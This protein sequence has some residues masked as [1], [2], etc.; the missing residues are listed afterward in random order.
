MTG[1]KSLLVNYSDGTNGVVTFGDGNKGVIHGKGDL[2]IAGLPPVQNVLFV[3]G[4]KANLLSISQLCD[5]H[6]T[7]SFNREKCLATSLDG[8]STLV[9]TRSADNCYMLQASN[10]CSR[11]SVDQST[12]WHHRLGHLNFRDLS[13]LLKI[14]AMVGVPAI[15]IHRDE[16]CGPCF[17]GKQVRS[18]HPAVTLLLTSRPLELLHVDLMGPMPI[19][20]ISGKRYVMVCVDDYTRFSWVSFLKEKS[21]TFGVFSALCLRIQNEKILKIAKVY[22]LRS[23]HGREFENTVFSDFCDSMGIA[24]EFSAP[25]TPQQNGVVE[26]KNRTLQEMARVMLHAKNVPQSFWA[27][28]VNTACYLS[29]RVHLRSGTT[30]TSYELW[31]GKPPTLHYLKVFGSDCYILN[32]RDARGKFDPKSDK[33][34]F[35]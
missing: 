25:K 1:N 9:G 19:A 11:A 28:A 18:S 17:Q 27:E 7:V 31:K 15:K 35:L 30:Q 16:K 5:D 4:L 34:V 24:H 33:A 3:K 13:R 23:D 12:L 22:R 32:D 6:Y 20:S 29:N 26:R 14:K 21:D 10:V 2:F 8:K